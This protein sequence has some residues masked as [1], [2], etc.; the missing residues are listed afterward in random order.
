[1]FW[2]F[3]SL[4]LYNNE[5]FTFYHHTSSSPSS[6]VQPLPHLL[7]PRLLPSQQT[8]IENFNAKMLHRSGHALIMP[9]VISVSFR[10]MR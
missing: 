1:M 5:R 2:L 10:S 6:N 3:Y 7:D 4:I 9:F 8:L